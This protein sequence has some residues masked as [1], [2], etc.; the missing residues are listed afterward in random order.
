MSNT[1]SPD[2]A[3]ELAQAKQQIAQLSLQLTHANSRCVT[4]E[5]AA[6]KFTQHLSSLRAR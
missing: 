5:D 3:H 4:W 6:D 2:T 1:P